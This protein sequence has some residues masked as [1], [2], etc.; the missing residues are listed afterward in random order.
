MAKLYTL[1]IETSKKEKNQILKVLFKQLK[2]I[3]TKVDSYKLYFFK[4]GV[5]KMG[6]K[7]LAAVC[8][9]ILGNL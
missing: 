8:G 3:G 1:G 6:D 9:D 4:R 2:I 5:K 7:N